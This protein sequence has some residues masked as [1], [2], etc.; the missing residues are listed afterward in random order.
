MKRTF[1]RLAL[2]FCLATCLVPAAS[3]SATT[4]PVPGLPA[5]ALAVMNQA[6]YANGQWFISVRDI[7]TGQQLISLN[8]DKLVEPGSVVKTYSMGAGWLRFGP[9][10]Q[11]VTPVKRQGKV[12]NGELKGD[13]TLVGEGDLTMGGRTKPDGKVDFTNLDHNDANDLP[14]ATLT[15]RT[16]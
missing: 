13:L 15:P 16:R 1:R 10:R 11:I 3:A 9:N 14:G 12:V 7:E 5:S 4:G 8:S 2:A 6:P